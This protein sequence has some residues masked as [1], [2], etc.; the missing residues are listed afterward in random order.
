MAPSSGQIFVVAPLP[1]AGNDL[2]ELGY[3]S[4]FVTAA[5]S[6]EGFSD[7]RGRRYVL[8]RHAISGTSAAAAGRGN[9]YYVNSV[10]SGAADWLVEASAAVSEFNRSSL[11][12]NCYQLVFRYASNN[13]GVLAFS[14]TWTAAD[15]LPAGVLVTAKVMDEK[16][17]ARIAAL[18]P[19]GLS[20]ADV[21]GGGESV[22]GRV[23][24]EGTIEVSRFIPFVNARP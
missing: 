6:G 4:V 15:R 20:S 23:L 24:R 18:R 3:L 5:G 19:N 2:Y 1:S 12:P 17:A 11:I 22:V 10:P 16:T 7:M 8:M 13:N 9:F 14:D 21:A